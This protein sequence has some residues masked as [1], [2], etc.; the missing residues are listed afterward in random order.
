MEKDAHQSGNQESTSN[1]SLSS[2]IILPVQR[3]PRY[4]LLVQTIFKNTSPKDPTY[5]HVKNLLHDINS[6]AQAVNDALGDHQQ[7][8]E[9]LAINNRFRAKAFEDVT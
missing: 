6:V 7:R 1:R 4:R 5:I 3:I 8:A 2:L 9:V